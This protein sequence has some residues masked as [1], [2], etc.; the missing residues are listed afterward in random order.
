MND[1][2][3]KEELKLWK[4]GLKP[5]QIKL[6]EQGAKSQSQACILNDMW[7]EWKEIAVKKKLNEIAKKSL[8][9]QDPWQEGETDA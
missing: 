3:W 1:E 6:L 4:P 7:C 2:N 9:I 8:S 5:F